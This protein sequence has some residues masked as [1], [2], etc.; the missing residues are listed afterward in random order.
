V[1][2]SAQFVSAVAGAVAVSAAM[3]DVKERR[4]PNRL[5]YPTIIVGLVLQTAFYGWAGFVASTEGVLLFGGVFFLFYF[6][7]AMGAGD[8]KLAA[9]LGSLVGPTAS[10]RVMFATA[11]AGGIIAIALMVVKGRTMETLRNTFSVAGFHAQHGLQTHPV[12]NL[13]NP[14]AIR[15]P[16]GVAFA[17]GTL[18]WSIFSVLGR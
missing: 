1:I 4:I 2:S 12:V 17:A 10:F 6:V 7:R 9:A 3:I 5:T 8:V 16:Y 14:T 11:V 15:M 18:Y 13:D